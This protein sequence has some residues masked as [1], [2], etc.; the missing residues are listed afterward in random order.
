MELELKK[1]CGDYINNKRMSKFNDCF[2]K[3]KLYLHLKVEQFVNER[4][5]SYE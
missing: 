4:K 1:I 2:K 3:C 5:T